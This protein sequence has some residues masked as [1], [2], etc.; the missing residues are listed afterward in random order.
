MER[1]L[2]MATVAFWFAV[3]WLLAITTLM[4][5]VKAADTTAV[6]TG[7]IL[8]AFFML[9]AAGYCTRLYRSVL[10]NSKWFVDMVASRKKA[11]GKKV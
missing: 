9:Q 1:Y 3:S 2:D 4:C 5:L 10:R 7:V 11:S 6:F 8:G